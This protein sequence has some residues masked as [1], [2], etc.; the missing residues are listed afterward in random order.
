M[1]VYSFVL[2]YQIIMTLFSVYAIAVTVRQWKEEMSRFLL[3]MGMLA[4]LANLG[5]LLELLSDNAGELVSAVCV[6][7]CG[8]AFIFTTTMIIIFKYCGKKNSKTID[9]CDTG[10]ECHRI[11]K[12]LDM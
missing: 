2:I 4:F 10:M 5:Y 9:F 8:A 11:F 12:C 3:L 1:T 6:R 7:Y